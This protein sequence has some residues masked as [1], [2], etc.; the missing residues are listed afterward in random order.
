MAVLSQLRYPT[1]R[2]AKLISGLLALILFFFVATAIVAGTLLARIVYPARTPAQLNIDLLLGHPSKVT[3]SVP[4]NGSREGIFFPGLRGAPTVVL[5][6]GYS[7]QRADILT[8]V[9]ALQEHHYNAFLFDFSGHGITPGTTTFGYEEVGEL[10]AA[11]EALAQRDDVDRMRFGV[12]GTDVGGY[13]ALYE[14]SSDARVRAL[15]VASVY[16]APVDMVIL[17]VD[18]TGLQKLPLVVSLCKFGFRMLNYRYR[19]EPPLVAGLGH[20]QGVPK[21]FIEARDEPQLYN[22]TMRLFSRS[23]DPRQQLPENVGY[24]QMSDEERQAYEN[25]IVTFFLQNL[26]TTATAAR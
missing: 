2:R 3:F 23:P 19:K 7:S 16:E 1:T 13:T 4:G 24:L 5:C 11:I 21:L 17:Q 22:S 8:M 18:R 20:L 15:A 6:H 9:T 26:P 12:W 10:H 14:A 25:A